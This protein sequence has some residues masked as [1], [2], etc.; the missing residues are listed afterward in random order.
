MD[1]LSRLV[2]QLQPADDASAIQSLCT[3][4]ASE[5]N[6]FATALTA[7]QRQ[8]YEDNGYLI[9]RGLLSQTECNIL[10][11]RFVE[12][13]RNPAVRLPETVLMTDITR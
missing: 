4:P 10:N 8:F 2:K 6:H 3:Q 7:T 5:T 9:V 13:A 12:Y 11:D 1:R